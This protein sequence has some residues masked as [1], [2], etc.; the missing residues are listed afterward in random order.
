MSTL[1][2]IRQMEDQA[3]LLAEATARGD[4]DAADKAQDALDELSERIAAE[5]D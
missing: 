5:D 2:I 3:Q 1:G 4:V